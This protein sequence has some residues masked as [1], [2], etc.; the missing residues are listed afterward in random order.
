[1]RASYQVRI[2]WL[3]VWVVVVILLGTRT[4]LFEWLHTPLASVI[5]PVARFMHNT[6]SN[7][8]RLSEL[9]KKQLIAQIETLQQERL[10]WET[11]VASVSTTARICT[12]LARTLSLPDRHA[13]FHRIGANVLGTGASFD[14]SLLLIDQGRNAGVQVGD[15]VITPEGALV[16]TVHTV[17][18]KSAY[19]R[20]LA[21][22]ASAIAGAS[23]DSGQLVGLVRGQFGLSTQLT[24]IPKAAQLRQG[25]LIQTAGMDEAI[26]PG[27]VI[28]SVEGIEEESNTELLR[29]SIQVRYSQENLRQV[30]L[31]TRPA[32]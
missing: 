8:T 28:G 20:T 32:S 23:V 2:A 21:H 27:I 26:P 11:A 16:G 18:A 12:D 10:F 29:A 13:S 17:A 6:V 19:I 7:D 24:L 14:T 4:P 3:V 5:A 9:S 15:T 1:M 30:I 22:P 31:L 25:S